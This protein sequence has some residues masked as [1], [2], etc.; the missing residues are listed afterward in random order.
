[1]HEGR[2]DNLMSCYLVRCLRRDVQ[3]FEKGIIVK[4]K[5]LVYAM[6]CIA[7]F[8]RYTFTM[9]VRPTSLLYLNF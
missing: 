1:M 7:V 6:M 3:N 4:C 9:R 8:E 5:M 2:N